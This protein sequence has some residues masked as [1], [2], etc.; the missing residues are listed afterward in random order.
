MKRYRPAAEQAVRRDLND[1]L[2]MLVDVGTFSTFER[3]F[4]IWHQAHA[5]LYI[6][7]GFAVII[8]VLAVHYY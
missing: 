8:H 1:Y 3:L 2:D 4:A 7:L 6:F 5:P